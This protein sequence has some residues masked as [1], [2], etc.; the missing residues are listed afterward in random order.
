[1]AENY[2]L[3]TS[4]TLGLTWENAPFTG[5]DEIIDYRLSIA[6]L[7]GEYSVISSGFTAAAFTATGLVAGT[8]YEFKVESRNSYSYSPLS[9]SITLLCAF[10][11]EAPLT[12]S[13]A[14]EN[15]L[16]KLEWSEPVTNGGA[17]TE[18]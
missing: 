16:V 4:T 15:E 8:T 13:T 5:G 2:F 11:P 14:N 3:R 10:K 17:I 6:E 12:V 7:G 18:Y 1:L 9:E